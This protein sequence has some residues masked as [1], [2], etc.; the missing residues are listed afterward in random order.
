MYFCNF[1]VYSF[2]VVP[3]FLLGFVIKQSTVAF[4]EMAPFRFD[5]KIVTEQRWVS[6]ILI[7]KFKRY[8]PCIIT[9]IICCKTHVRQGAKCFYCRTHR[10]LSLFDNITF[11]T[12]HMAT[13][14]GWILKKR[15]HASWV[16]K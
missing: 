13:N 2:S 16:F 1:T 10:S 12:Y 5:F 8:Y 11:L 14:I 7:F 15:E 3:T 6:Q 4:L 9:V